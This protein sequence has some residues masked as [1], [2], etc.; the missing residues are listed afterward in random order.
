MKR[1]PETGLY[2]RTV[3]LRRGVYDYQYVLGDVDSDGNGI[4]QEWLT[5]EGNDWRT[6]NR[7]TALVYY[8][9]RHFGGFDRIIGIVRGKSPG[10][11]ESGKSSSSVYPFVKQSNSSS[12]E[13]RN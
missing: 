2:K 11:N 4:N 6:V 7:F 9:D 1:D 10:T 8:Y 13:Q 3:W 5:L 12:K